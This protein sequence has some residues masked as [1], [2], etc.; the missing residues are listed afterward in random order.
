MNA[1]KNNGYWISIAD[2]MSGL[3]VV[4]MFI[5]LAYMHEIKEVNN[6]IIYIT[7]G[8]QDTENNFEI[9]GNEQ[10]N[11]SAGIDTGTFEVLGFVQN[12]TDDQ[13]DLA[14]GGFRPPNATGVTR[15]RGAT[16]GV[17]LAADF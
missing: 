13:Y 9:S 8:F 7:E 2:L 17:T 3:M 1:Q 16:Y 4:F 10:L 11:L 6:G 15:A 12:A 14:F 5:A